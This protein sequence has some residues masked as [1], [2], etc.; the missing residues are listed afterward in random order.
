[1]IYL[2]K[3]VFSIIRIIL[4]L[5]NSK[6]ASSELTFISK[7]VQ[8]GNDLLGR[9]SSGILLEDEVKQ[10]KVF[11]NKKINIAIDVGANVGSYSD[12]LLSNFDIKKLYLFE[13]SQEAFSSL[14]LKYENFGN[15]KVIN[16]GLSNKN[17]TVALYAD[18]KGSSR[19][20]IYNRE[21]SHF[22]IEINKTEKAKLIRFDEFYK[23]ELDNKTVDL[24]KLDIEGHELFALQGSL[25]S[26]KSIKVIQ[27]EF[28][29]CNIDSKTY[30]QNFFYFFKTNDFDIFRI[31]PNGLI[32]IK[33][34]K[35]TEEHFQYSN[36]F[37]VNNKL[38]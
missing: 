26:L 36:Y 34:Y 35:E 38:I 8:L 7:T 28:G 19:S 10:L 33:R 5:Y 18:T 17:E 13:P 30:F 3:F 24:L 25:E 29:G 2:H 6:N 11:L 16:E 15:V 31:R 22:N 9:G 37:A 1:M 27:F 14:K 12:M 21:L 32:Q 4:S 23:S 20:S